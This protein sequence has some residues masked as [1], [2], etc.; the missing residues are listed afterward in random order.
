MHKIA[1]DMERGGWDSVTVTGTDISRNIH[2]T[3]LQAADEDEESAG[4]DLHIKP[5]LIYDFPSKLPVEAAKRCQGPFP[6]IRIHI[7]IHS[8]SLTHTRLTK[9]QI[10]NVQ[11]NER[12]C[13]I[14]AP[15]EQ[16]D[17]DS[18][19]QHG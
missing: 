16:K 19:S 6:H 15:V 2:K 5:F 14:K 8:L 9:Q 11:E 17:N 4:Q 13:T 18:S 12:R 10:T 7:H 3:N 1:A